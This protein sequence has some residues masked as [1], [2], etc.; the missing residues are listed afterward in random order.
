MGSDIHIAVEKRDSSGCWRT[1][2]PE[3]SAEVDH[4]CERNYG[5]FGYFG[6]RL[7]DREGGGPMEF[8]G[9]PTDMDPASAKYD[10]VCIGEHGQTWAL[11]SE[12]L[13]TDWSEAT[14]HSAYWIAGLGKLL[15]HGLADDIRL[16]IGFDS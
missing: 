6:V 2:F 10:G 15:A 16:L 14:H 3:D 5:V 12:L 13:L 7:Y 4:L 8:R 1:L 9:M 11:L